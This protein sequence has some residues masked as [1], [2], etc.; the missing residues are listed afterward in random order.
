MQTA[1]EQLGYDPC[2]HMHFSFQNPMECEMWTE[3]FNAKFHNKGRKYTRE[4][5]DHLL[6]HC[7]AVTDVPTAAFI[8]ELYEAYPDAKVVIVQRDPEKWFKSCQQTVM[9]FAGSGNFPGSLE[10]PALY[11]LDRWLCRRLAP[12]MGIMFSSL[13][14][15]ETRDPVKVKEN[16]IQGYNK[17]YDEVRRV[18]PEEQRLEFS[19]DQGWEPLCK[20]LGDEIPKTPFPHKNDSSSF[21]DGRRVLLNRMWIRAFKMNAPYVAVALSVA[22]A[23][24]WQRSR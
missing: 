2:Y 8:P 18:V 21:Q 11:L 9:S 10:M 15:S 24:W 17:A 14:G 3:A 12:M 16:W 6:G 5:W 19:L 1:L 13:F 20:F 23:W 4:D 7:Q 22:A